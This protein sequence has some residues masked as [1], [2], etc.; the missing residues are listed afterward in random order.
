MPK[1]FIPPS[2]R[3]LTGDESVVDVDGATLGQVLD[4]LDQRYPGLKQRICQGNTIRPGIAVA[5]ACSIATVGL[6]QKTDPADEIHFLP[7][8]GGG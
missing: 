1:V 4:N 5:V 6:L 3:T 8:V 7:A 2:M